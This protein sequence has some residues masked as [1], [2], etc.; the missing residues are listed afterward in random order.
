MPTELFKKKVGPD[1]L[2]MYAYREHFGAFVH[3]WFFPD[4][5]TSTEEMHWA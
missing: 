1:K 5:A 3:A 4:T 2:K